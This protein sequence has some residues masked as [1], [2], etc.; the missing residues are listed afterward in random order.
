MAQVKDYLFLRKSRTTNF[1]FK[2]Q[3]IKKKKQPSFLSKTVDVV[4]ETAIPVL[5]C[6]CYP[7]TTGPQYDP[8]E[9]NKSVNDHFLLNLKVVSHKDF[10]AFEPYPSQE[11]GGKR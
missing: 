6:A 5:K 11:K 1:L 8:G 7:H 10:L 9:I 4:Q 2:K 3:E